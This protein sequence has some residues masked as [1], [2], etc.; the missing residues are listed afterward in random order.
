M[1][2][3]IYCKAT[4]HVSGVTAPIIRSIKN[5]IH[6]LL[7]RSYYWYRYSP[8]TWSDRDGVPIRPRFDIVLTDIVGFLNDD[9]CYCTKCLPQTGISCKSRFRK[10]WHWLVS[11]QGTGVCVYIHIYIYVHICT[12]TYVYISHSTTNDTF[13]LRVIQSHSRRYPLYLTVQM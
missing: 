9:G 4:L 1:Q 5:C 11:H 7:Y 8:P 10:K 13:E 2:I 6:S 12:Y 3:F